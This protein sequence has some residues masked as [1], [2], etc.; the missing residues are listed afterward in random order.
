MKTSKIIFISLLSTI[1]L[2]ILAAAID[3]KISG[4][5]NAGNG[6]DFKMSRQTL[7]D[8]KVLLVNNSVNITLVRKDSSFLE[9]T[10][11][12]D[13]IVPKVNYT[14]RGDTLLVSDFEKP[15]HRSSS[16]TIFA[17][18]SLQ[19]IQL[20][21]SM[22]STERLGI[23]K[24]VFDLDHSYLFL[25]Q[26]LRLRYPFGAID[27]TAKNHSEISSS[28][29][30]LDSLTIQ[31]RNSEANFDFFVKNIRGSLSDSSTI[32]ARQPQEISLKK[33]ASSKINVYE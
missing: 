30:S 26:H 33:D 15:V 6:S 9:V 13:S 1:T 25:N 24:L 19:K 29:F 11:L 5:L 7:P 8:F 31:L 23:G 21:N 16:L 12:K 27:L 14:F 18:D 32:R 28:E 4:H 10:S 22:V 20:T 17:T 3:I 2:L